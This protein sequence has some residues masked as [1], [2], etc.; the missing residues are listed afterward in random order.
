[1]LSLPRAGM[2]RLRWFVPVLPLALGACAGRSRPAGPAPPA[3]SPAVKVSFLVFG[4][5]PE[6]RAYQ[7]MVDRFE[8][9]RSDV[10]VEVMHV[11]SQSEYRKRMETDFAA[12]T[13][14]DVVLINYRRYTELAARGV[15]QP[16]G[17]YLEKSTVIQES[18][19]FPE[20]LA[21]FRWKGT[22]MGIPQ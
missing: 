8:S 17:P 14:A 6:L 21:P 10:D 13:P 16:L 15:L 1:M 9:D 11:P 3:G 4:D 2:C 12:G 18:D 19:F 20:A 7:R 5:P 22:L